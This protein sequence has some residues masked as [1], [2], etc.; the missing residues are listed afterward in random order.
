M[1]LLT[2]DDSINHIQSLIY[3]KTQRHA[4]HFDL[5]V[6]SIAQYQQAGQLDF[7]GSEFKPA[8]TETIEP[9]KKN[10]DDDYGWWNL[11]R[12]T[13]HATFNEQLDID[14]SIAFAL[15]TGHSHA[16]KAGII[17]D[18]RIITPDSELQELTFT[19]Q[20]PE[21]G[22]KIKE[23]ARIARLHLFSN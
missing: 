23:N 19:F 5:T 14:N 8:S 4:N 12:E 18:T 7:G 15:I 17:T 2:S 3:E 11:D 9:V 21:A 6:K 20:V 22:V 13:Y 16:Q 1:R 10:Q